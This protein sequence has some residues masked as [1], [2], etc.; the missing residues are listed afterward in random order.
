MLARKWF[1]IITAAVLFCL[2]GSVHAESQT[3][4]VTQTSDD[5]EESASGS[6]SLNSSDLELVDDNSL[7][8]VGIR[9]RGVNVPRGA[10]ITNAYV[11]FTCDET[12]SLNPCGLVV[13]GQA[14]DDAAT[15]A[16]SPRNVS[17]R[18][19]T[20]A[21]VNWS[22][23]NWSRVGDAG[24]DQRT[25]NLSQVVQEIVGRDGWVEGNALAIIITGTGARVAQAYGGAQA[26]LHLEWSMHDCV[27]GFAQAEGN[28]PED[29]RT[30]SIE[31]QL[32]PPVSAATVT[33]D[34]TVTDITTDSRDY[35]PHPAS[36]RLSFPPG[37]A[38]Q[39]IRI[40]PRADTDPEGDEQFKVNLSNPRGGSLDVALGAITEHIY[41]IIDSSPKVTFREPSSSGDEAAGLV[42]VRV[43]LST[44]WMQTVTVN[45]AVKA[46]G[47]TAQSPAD[48]TLLGSGTLTF[49]P[50]SF[51]QFID[52][53]TLD[54][55][56]PENSER[57]VLVLSNPTNASLGSPAEYVYT[58]NASELPPDWTMWRYDAN[59]SGVSPFA[60]SR[61][62][63]LQWELRLPRLEQA[64]PDQGSRIDY[65]R[66]YQ[67]IVMGKTL[68]VGSSATDSVTAYDT[69]TGSLKWRFFADAPVRFA[70][71]GWTDDP[72]NPADDRLF[73]V[74]DDG[75]LYCLDANDGSV[76]WKFLGAPSG[77][78]GI[79]NKRLGSLWPARGGPALLDDTV[80]FSAGI[81]PFM[82]VFVYAL[83]AATGDCLW[84]NDGSGSVYMT[85][86][87]NADSFAGLAPQGYLVAVGDRL[88][89]PNSRANAAGLDRYTGKLLYCD[90]NSNNQRSTNHVAAYGEQ[91]NNSGRLFNIADGSAAGSLEDGAVMSAA[92][93]YTQT[94]CMAGDLLYKG[95]NGSIRA[96][97]LGGN[98]LWQASIAGTPAS[99][100]A[101]DGRLF[102]VT[103]EGSIY[104]YGPARVSNP[105]VISEVMD[106]VAWPPADKWTTTAQNI[107]A[108]SGVNEG[109]CLV[110]GVGSGRL[111]EELARAAKSNAYDLHVIGLDPDPARIEMLRNR[112]HSMGILN[113]QLSAMVGDISTAGLPPYLA[114]L[115]VSEDLEA[116]G[117]GNASTFV[118]ET[119]YSLR[120]Y[121]GKICFGVET[122][123]L[124]QQAAGTGALANADVRASGA[125][126]ILERVGALPGSADWTHLYADASNTVVSKDTLV[127]APLGL[128]W[129]GGSVNTNVLP[130]HI[131]GP[132][133]QVV[134]GRLFIE[135]AHHM[136]ARD[137]YTG[138]V[139]WERNLP[140]LGTY[141][142]GALDFNPAHYSGANVVG[143]NYVCA[144]D[145]VYIA[146]GAAC[147]RLDPTT[148]DTLQTFGLTQGATA[149]ADFVQLRIWNNLLIVG[150]DP[151]IYP[152]DVGGMN[153]NETSCRDLVVMDRYSGQ[154]KWQRRA[155]HSFHHNTIIVGRGGSGDILFCIDRVPPGQA[156]ALSRRGISANN[157]NAPWRLLA[158]DVM[159]GAETWSTTS[160]VFGTWLGYCEEFD[161]LLQT[162][163]RS[164][165]ITPGEPREQIAYRGA[166]GTWLWNASSPGG[167]CL[168]LGDMVIAQNPGAGGTARN[169]LTGQPIYREHPITG[170][171]VLWEFDRKYGCNTFVGSPNLITF[172]SGA[173][174]YFDLKNNMGTGNLGGFKSGCSP[175]LI[176]ANGVL[177]APDYT[178]TCTCGYH[179]Q[180]SL[181][182]IH[183]PEAEMWT[184]ATGGSDSRPVK[185]LGINFGAPGD[186]LSD[187]GVLWLDYPSVGGSSPDVGVTTIPAD[188]ECFRRHSAWFEGG[189]LPWVTA[190]G[191]IGL[192]RVTI[193]TNNTQETEYLVRLFFAEPENLQR[194]ERVFDVVLQ[195]REVLAN[196]DITAEEPAP[197]LGVVREF[198]AIK[199]TT[200]ITLELK[201][202]IGRPVIC[203]IE[204]IGL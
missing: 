187:D 121:G 38:S 113:E 70:P 15:F 35:T 188:P 92:G 136:T 111:M 34:Y 147:L 57:I 8:T 127:K 64:W 165:D 41:T 161:V 150:A 172:R 141:Y 117:I 82:G 178:R 192:T 196:F 30:I 94:F 120:P 63:F 3:I 182:L 204:V 22:P 6:V 9:F 66:C 65:D 189:P 95:T 160:N 5:A 11:Q 156:D 168:L 158:L 102:V 109:Y 51:W 193:P 122:L 13:Q 162:G 25:P 17:S 159:T 59:R 195:S 154:V 203:G 62:L 69:Q 132:S 177:N 181:A 200:Q 126:A 28:G 153:W 85:Q 100:L 91:F 90:L 40:T 56:V 78:K 143:A 171:P 96:T 44:P 23:P 131:H 142:K 32:S 80:Y 48:Y 112:W 138:R 157:P 173:A 52:L 201:P 39:A 186:R 16:T 197:G 42:S 190:S 61:E 93:N 84:L 67:P 99:M 47:S 139:I 77:K 152:G 107:L 81:W 10:R 83:E 123:G 115:I 37:T 46:E 124:L 88:I 24:P 175:S 86:P 55:V 43:W 137:V 21:T 202:S 1:A 60:L 119:F 110:L 45:Y 103:E 176:P 33:V 145:G 191:A 146:R 129:F 183:M 194:G 144:D 68:F 148:G 73:V 54:D 140:N 19:R 98:Q 4:A 105:A 27:V 170:T 134:G 199:A 116:A 128:L 14:A 130:R 151:V 29:G 106:W 58:I 2:S 31:V 76:I 75:C 184:Y 97:T 87:H 166:D 179:N 104:C 198:Q 155:E 36:G 149:G 118:E 26:V 72:A 167:P 114:H 135:G 108:A 164:G 12:G 174:G 79:G 7:Q 18:A 169:V 89:V 133:E 125:F 74:S 53:M 71:A 101:A 50:G 20:A 185:K 49:P 180:T 163:R